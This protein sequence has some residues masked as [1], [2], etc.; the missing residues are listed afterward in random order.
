MTKDAGYSQAIENLA[1]YMRELANETQRPIL[2][3]NPWL[4]DEDEETKISFCNEQMSEEQ[5]Q[6]WSELDSAFAMIMTTYDVKM[7]EVYAD[8]FTRIMEYDIE[9][10]DFLQ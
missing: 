6:R 5:R 1:F 2:E 10:G 8:T 7:Y 4:Y 9:A 3:A